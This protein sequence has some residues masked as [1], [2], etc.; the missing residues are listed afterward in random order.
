MT[1]T[2]PEALIAKLERM[3]RRDTE[4]AEREPNE[5]SKQMRLVDAE[6]FRRAAADL[7]AAPVAMRERAEGAALHEADLLKQR[8][9]EA[10]DAGHD[11]AADFYRESEQTAR[12]IAALIRALP[13]DAPA[14]VDPMHGLR[15]AAGLDPEIDT[16]LK[17][18]SPGGALHRSFP[19]AADGRPF[20]PMGE[21][22]M[23]AG[24][25]AEDARFVAVQLAQNGL[26]LVDRRQPAPVDPVAG[27]EKRIEELTSALKEVTLHRDQ[28]LEVSDRLF[29]DVAALF[30]RQIE[31]QDAIENAARMAEQGILSMDGRLAASE[32]RSLAPSEIRSLAPRSS[33][34]VDPV[35]EAA[36]VLLADLRNREGGKP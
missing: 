34:P 11:T 10:D 23:T 27:Q 13:L 19:A 16:A 35:A 18:Y 33:T 26:T 15:G 28:L 36:K 2:S 8:A 25:S 31:L 24:L 17:A 20:P 22:L 3:A 7:R 6:T 30:A 29:D 21:E 9:A 12:N 32:I 4:Q 5:V 1:D 14:P